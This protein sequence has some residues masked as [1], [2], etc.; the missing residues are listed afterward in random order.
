MTDRLNPIESIMLRAGQDPTLRMTVGALLMLD[1]SPG[2]G[3]LEEHVVAA[4]KRT[5]RLRRRPDDAGASRLRPAWNEDEEL[6]VRHHVRS[7]TMARG[8]PRQLLDLL[9]MFDAMSFDPDRPP[10]DITLVEGSGGFGAALYLRAHHVVIDGMGGLRLLGALL[11]EREWPRT[12]R[13]ERLYRRDDGDNG[14]ADAPSRKAGTI[15][16]D[17]AKATRPVRRRVSAAREV[18]LAGVAVRGIQR[19][20]DVANPVSRQVMVTG[21]PLSPLFDDQSSMSR[22]EL[23]RS[24]TRDTRRPRSAAAA[25]ICSSRSPQPASGCTTNGWG[26][27]VASC[28]WRRLLC[29]A[30]RRKSAG[31]GSSPRA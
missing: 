11:D 10:R 2:A 29:R 30:A 26:R 13:S 7:V 5:P 1:R 17:L 6:D 24:R 21:G 27:P 23:C 28:G 20:L 19:A 14:R 22:F 16:I 25:T 18:D 9:A 12:M 4:A 31:T 15:T 8:S 3:A